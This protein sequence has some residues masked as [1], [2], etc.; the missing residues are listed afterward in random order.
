MNPSAQMPLFRRSPSPPPQPQKTGLFG[1]GRRSNSP[2]SPTRSSTGSRLL[3]RNGDPSINAA[4]QKV[5]D[6]EAAE[7]EADKALMAARASVREAKQQVK[8]LEKE[9]EEE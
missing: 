2:D 5:A 4:R 8:N 9:A 1:G 3:G 7:R 6:A